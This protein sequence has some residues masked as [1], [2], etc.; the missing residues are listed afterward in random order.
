M[1]TPTKQDDLRE[2]VMEA[3]V[4]SMMLLRHALDR[5]PWEHQQAMAALVGRGDWLALEVSMNAPQADW[6]V[7]IVA[8]SP[9]GVRTVVADLASGAPAT[10][11]AH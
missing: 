6:A 3:K 4:A 2:L 8:L 5:F 9:E 1:K 11:D 10:D 7:R